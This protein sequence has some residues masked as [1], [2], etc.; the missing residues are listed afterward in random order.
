MFIKFIERIE[1]YI[2]VIILSLLV[3]DLFVNCVLRY[4]FRNPF[5]WAEEFAVYCF[6]WVTFI[7]ASI[8]LK[9]GKH[10]SITILPKKISI[11]TKNHLQI[12]IYLFIGVLIIF[13]IIQ[14][15]KAI[16]LQ[17]DSHTIALPVKL[18]SLYFFALPLVMSSISMLLTV[19]YFLIGFFQKTG[20]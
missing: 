6:L 5:A 10:L 2:G 8:A 1:L 13:L 11:R 17:R 15:N 16:Y 7:G 12:F 19:I 18:P 14:G 9:R 4:V 20:E 3:V